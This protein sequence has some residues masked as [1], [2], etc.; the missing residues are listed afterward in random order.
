MSVSTQVAANAIRMLAVE[1]IQKAKSGHPGAPMGMA[2][3]VRFAAAEAVAADR[4]E[5]AVLIIF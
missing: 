3:F 1:A 5:H 4:V 2:E